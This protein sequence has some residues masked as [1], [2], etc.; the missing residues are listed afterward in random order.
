MFDDRCNVTLQ[1]IRESWSL[2]D[3][4]DAGDILNACDEQRHF[5]EMRNKSG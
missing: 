4:F 2:G 1:E 3:V 5:E